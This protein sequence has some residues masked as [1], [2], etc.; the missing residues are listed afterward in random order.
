M[1]IDSV[2]VPVLQL[3]QSSAVQFDICGSLG[4]C[5]SGTLPVVLLSGTASETIGSW[6]VHYCCTIDAAFTKAQL[7][8]FFYSVGQDV[9]IFIAK[10]LDTLANLSKSRGVCLSCISLFFCII[11]KSHTP[12]TS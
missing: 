2:S 8:Q 10:G 12:L 9:S 5:F 7:Q 4:S 3:T 1:L 11:I 6:Q